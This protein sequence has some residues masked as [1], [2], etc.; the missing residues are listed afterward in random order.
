MRT[1]S[2]MTIEFL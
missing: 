2:T 1:F